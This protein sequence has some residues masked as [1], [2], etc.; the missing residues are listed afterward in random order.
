MNANVTVSET[1]EHRERNESEREYTDRYLSNKPTVVLRFEET[2]WG[3]S[4]S[5]VMIVSHEAHEIVTD[6]LDDD[7]KAIRAA[8]IIARALGQKKIQRKDGTPM[9]TDIDVGNN[10]ECNLT[11]Y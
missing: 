9:V 10:R 4:L 11:S 6:F 3:A 5:M 8:K 7:A 2:S 1:Q